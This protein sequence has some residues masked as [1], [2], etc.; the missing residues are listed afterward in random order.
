[1]QVLKTEIFSKWLDRLRDIHA[2][3]KVLARI[4]RFTTG[5]PGDV[6]SLGG[7]L[8]EMISYG[9]GYRVNFTEKREYL[10]VLIAGGDKRTQSADI[11]RARQVLKTLTL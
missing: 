9:P 10:I 2:R 7:G 8:S 6:Q 5:N 3:A 11:R 4:E 1:M